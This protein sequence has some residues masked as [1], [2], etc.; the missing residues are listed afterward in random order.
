MRDIGGHGWLWLSYGL[1]IG[2]LWVGYGLVMGGY[3]LVM[4]G[5]WLSYVMLCYVMLCG[6][7]LSL[8]RCLNRSG[9]GRLRAPPKAGLALKG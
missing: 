9:S 5:L 2:G 7:C 4:G 6:Y 3:G 8:K 1:V